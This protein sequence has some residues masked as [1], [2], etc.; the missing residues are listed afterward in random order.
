MQRLTKWAL[1]LMTALGA[2]SCGESTQEVGDV[3]Q[4]AI[5]ASVLDT[6]FKPTSTNLYSPQ[7]ARANGVAFNVYRLGNVVPSEVIT[8][9]KL[10]T[11]GI[12]LNASSVPF[13][14][15]SRVVTTSY[16]LAEGCETGKPDFNLRT[17]NYP[18]NVQW[19]LFDKLPIAVTGATT[20]PVLPLVK[21]KRWKGT[22]AEQCNAIKDVTS[23][24]DGAFGGSAEDGETYALRAVID[25]SADLA[26]LHPE[27]TFGFSGGWYRGMQLGYFD[28]GAVPVDAEGNLKMMDGVQV[29]VTG[30]NA[31][32]FVF[33][34]RPGDDVWSPVVRLRTF[35]A[36]AGSNVN[37]YHT[38][39]YDAPCPA[40][41]IDVRNLK[42]SGALFVV[43]SNL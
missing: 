42:Y 26:L 37:S 5:D 18:E 39:C 43:G 3:Y 7:L 10:T 28:G 29:G 20:P 32:A 6:K 36:P 30:S 21:V 41:T 40:G 1:G 15:A 38:L 24:T 22:A 27:S 16:E 9:G 2:V 17:D 11:A 31:T 33:Q 19:P 12:P 13:L 8:N 23:L 34:A 14:P 25:V 35:T 4:G